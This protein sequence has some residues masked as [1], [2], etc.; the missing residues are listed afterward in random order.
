MATILWL[1]PVLPLAGFAVLAIL[2]RT[3]PR[4]FAAAIGTGSVGVSAAL[5]ILLAA[6][7]LTSPPTGGVLTATL[8]TWFEAGG[9]KPAIAFRLDALSLVFVLVVTFVGFLIHLYSTAFMA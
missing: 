1:I 9:L 3:M 2:G 7:F 4:R 8:W 6:R 5:A